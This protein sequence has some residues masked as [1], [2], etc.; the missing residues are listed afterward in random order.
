MLLRRRIS[1]L[2]VSASLL[3]VVPIHGQVEPADVREDQT[4]RLFLDCNAIGCFD[5]DYLR[6]EI[7]FVNWVRDV[8]DAD[9]YL[10]VTALGTGAGG[11][12]SEL[13]FSGQ[14]RFEGMTDTL[15][16]VSGFD[17]TTDEQR[18]GLTKIIK[19]GLMRYVGLT[20]MAQ[21]I[22]IGL[23]RRTPGPMGPGGPRA[24]TSPEDDRWDFWVFR[25]R[26]SGGLGG[27]TSYRSLRVSGGVTANR[28]TE[29]W[30][31][32]LSLS[33]SYDESKYDYE[34]VY[35]DLI[36]KRSHTFRGTVVGSISDH[37]SAGLRASARSATYYNFDF[38]GSLAPVLEYSV[39]PYEESTRRSLTFQYTFEGVYHDYR[40][41]TVFFKTEDSFLQ[42]NL[43]ATLRFTRRWG[44]AWVGMEAGHRLE[45]IDLHHVSGMGGIRLRLSRGLTLSIHGTASRV[46][47][48]TTIAARA[49]DTVED[50]LARRR[51][52][53]TDYN[54]ST[55]IS[56]SYAFGSI[57][58]NIVNP[59]LGGGGMGM[60]MPIII[61]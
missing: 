58:N 23:R 31:V 41:E 52:L 11:A 6:M 54:Y 21:E 20:S 32:S 19:I 1:G 22:E 47:D 35:S 57:F 44:D 56:L 4:V 12:S 14:G 38:A 60:G 26:G 13:I 49:G 10:L 48:L 24:V 3:F 7:P 25:V 40:E 17:A 18:E 8:R 59:R 5:L 33:T 34:G 51:Q 45:D 36:I 37:W 61:M 50:I 39:F 53:Q 9:V 43:D 28:V 46:K 27:R 42:H 15:T 2:V 30:K 55:S 29:D 16:Y